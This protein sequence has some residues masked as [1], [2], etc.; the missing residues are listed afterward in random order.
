[1]LYRWYAD[2]DKN[3]MVAIRTDPGGRHW[4]V[5]AYMTR[6]IARGEWLWVKS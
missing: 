1:M 2:I 4:V 5:T 3:V 6:D